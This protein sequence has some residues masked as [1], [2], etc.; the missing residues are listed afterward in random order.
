M[1]GTGARGRREAFWAARDVSFEV[2][3]GSATALIGGNGAGKSTLLRLAAG[4]SVPTEG[5]LAVPPQTMS[6]LGL[7]ASFDGTLTGAEN[8]LTALVVN[9]LRRR[10]AAA[11]L[12]HVQEF[13]ELEDFFESPVRT[14]SAGMGLRLAFA[15]ATRLPSDALL[16][17]EVLSVGDLRFQ[18]KCVDHLLGLRANGATIL[19]ATHD[20][21]QVASLCPDA[22]WLQAGRVRLAGPS[23]EVIDAYQSAMRSR[24]LEI[25]PPPGGDRSARRPGAATEPLRLPGSAS[26]RRA[27]QRSRRGGDRVRRRA[28]RRGAAGRR[29]AAR[30]GRAGHDHMARHR[31][32]RARQEPRRPGDGPADQAVQI[33]IERLDL[34]P[35]DYLVDVGAY[36]ADWSAA[37]DYHWGAHRLRVVGAP[38]TGDA[39]LRPPVR[40]SVTDAAGD[41]SPD[42]LT[43]ARPSGNLAVRPPQ[44]GQPGLCLGSPAGGID[45]RFCASRTPIQPGQTMH[46][47]A[48]RASRGR[49]CWRAKSI[50]MRAGLPR[51]PAC[52]CM[53]AIHSSQPTMSGS[54][55]CRVNAEACF[56][57]TRR[58]SS[59][60]ASAA[61]LMLP[62]WRTRPTSGRSTAVSGDASAS[63]I[64]SSQSARM[65]S[66]FVESPDLPD[67]VGT[68][69]HAGCS[70]GHDVVRE[71][72]AWQRARI[73]RAM[74]VRDPE[75]AIDGRRHPCSTTRSLR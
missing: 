47:A 61:K 48:R 55:R 16:V 57:S 15:V 12:P 35:G 46:D 29:E 25:T 11:E 51:R 22:V 66:S 1:F 8:A 2:P 68:G 24:T 30:R 69:Q 27:T 52:R 67:E 70:T 23:R 54:D 38:A 64:Q 3:A 63:R 56:R 74:L 9:G 5:T 71:E 32:A 10:A 20:L 62:P 33:T 37:Y 36:Q 40:W 26:R 6:V 41:G 13:A 39:V 42:R 59:G 28:R 53:S 49:R 75:S 45:R 31:S 34:A 43:P 58:I 44:P 50:Q 19:M 4:L 17:D 72:R 73:R 18:A 60:T 65:R 7:G 14:Y 21:D